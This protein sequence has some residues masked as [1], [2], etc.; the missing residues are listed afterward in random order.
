M[1]AGALVLLNLAVAVPAVAAAHYLLPPAAEPPPPPVRAP[2]PDGVDPERVRRL[3]A[4]V[5]ELAAML[6]RLRAE[7][8]EARK[9][10]AEA[11]AGLRAEVEKER[12]KANAA[13]VLL[14]AATG[15][16]GKK[17]PEMDAFAKEVSKAMKQGIRQE[18]R[19]ISDLV[20]NPSPEALEQRR[21]QLKMFA[22]MMG[23]AAGLDQAQVA[24]FEGILND[25]D[26][27]AR[28]ELRPLLQ[29]VEDYR[30]VDYPKVKKVTEDSFAGQNE[31]I[32]RAFP[33][34]KSDRLRQQLEPV[35]NLFGAMLDE[36]ERQSTA[37]APR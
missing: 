2:A 14:A 20:V 4:R 16:P 10:S 34:E 17:P 33:K 18:F 3:E 28:E 30:Q 19:R 32:D 29:G 35:R 21:K 31:Q 11:E 12:E 9:R 22:A 5:D 6:D 36:L 13:E 1:K 23:N 27:R 15:D 37:E 25:T 8:E 7:S 26:E 24:T